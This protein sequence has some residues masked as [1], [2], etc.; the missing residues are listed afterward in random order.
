[1]CFCWCFVVVFLGVVI[2]QAPL[3]KS[4]HTC[5]GHRRTRA[6]PTRPTASSILYIYADGMRSLVAGVSAPLHRVGR[7]GSQS[8]VVFSGAPVHECDADGM[9]SVHRGAQI[10]VRADSGWLLAAL[11][12]ARAQT[13]PHTSGATQKPPAPAGH[14][15]GQRRASMAA[16]HGRFGHAWY[17]LCTLADALRD[18]ARSRAHLS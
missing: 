18:A 16:S 17:D 6:A 4:S 9:Q 8:E 11:A 2:S 15:H 13:F 3:S 12:A 1:M 7:S 14:G 5:A 10:S